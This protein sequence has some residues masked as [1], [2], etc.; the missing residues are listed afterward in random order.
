MEKPAKA[1]GWQQIRELA[2][3]NTAIYEDIFDFIPRNYS[4]GMINYEIYDDESD[5]IPALL[6]P[7]YRNKF[8]EVKEA[9]KYMPFSVDFWRMY[10]TDFKYR[11]LLYSKKQK[12]NEVKGYITLLPIHWTEGENNLIDYH[13]A[14][15]D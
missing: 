6:W 10:K 13:T 7:V 11:E 15:I 9:A 14:L 8:R 1:D 5:G 12:L 2:L 4:N 3:K